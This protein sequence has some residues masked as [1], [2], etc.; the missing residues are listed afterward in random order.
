MTSKI[1]RSTE[2]EALEFPFSELT[3]FT[4]NHLFYVRNHFPPPD[5]DI[6]KWFL[7]V[8]VRVKKL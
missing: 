2:P 8:E 6:E 1:R 4:P 3:K 7:T 5:I